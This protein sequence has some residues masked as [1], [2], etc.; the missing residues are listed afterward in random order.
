MDKETLQVL[1]QQSQ[2]IPLLIFA[3][4]LLGA[5]ILITTLRLYSKLRNTSGITLD[6]YIA[7]ASTVRLASIQGVVLHHVSRFQY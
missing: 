4:V 5:A 1:C 2:Q 6:D 7:L 3:W